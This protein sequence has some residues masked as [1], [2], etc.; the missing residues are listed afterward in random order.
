ML[1]ADLLWQLLDYLYILNILFAIGIIFY[2]RRNPTVTLT[3]LL[4]LFLMPVLGL[5]LYL[6]LGQDLRKK[7]MFYLKK[8]EEESFLPKLEQQDQYLHNNQ[9]LFLNPRSSEYRDIIHLHLNS[10]QSLFS[11]NNKVDIFND[12][13]ELFQAMAASIQRAEKYIHLEYYII[14]NDA[15]GRS[16]RDILSRKAAEGVEVRLLYDGMGCIHLP[17]RF[18]Q[19]LLQAG[20]EVA[21]FLPPF[22][23]FVNLRMNYRNHRKICI[24]DGEEGYIGGFN[25]GDE[26]LGLSKKYGYWR[27]THLRIRGTALDGLHL[28]FLLDWRYA[29]DHDFQLREDFFPQRAPQG[30]TGVQIVSSGPDAKWSSIKDGFLKMIGSARQNIYIQTPYF[31]PDESILAA[32]KIA[33]LSGLDVRLMI[34]GKADHLIVHWANLSYVGEMLEAGVR[35]YAYSE[36]RFLHSKVMMVDGFVSTVGSANMDIRS[37]HLNFE[38]NA[39]IYDESVCR[40]LQAAFFRDIKNSQEITM[41]IYRARPVYARMK[42][43]VSRLLSP[44]L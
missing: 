15:T 11:Q 21:S 18:F 3:W 26:Y 16:L 20:G 40:N 9:M 29:C 35:C 33:A 39:F 28:R 44:L 32:L 42:E 30:N 37:F 2:E 14:Q 1:N 4:V 13:Q 17:R 36:Q 23:P 38:V 31:I 12:G 22:F 25:I 34:P 19:P 27:D 10:S 8:E 5:I 24:I 7:K 41:E 43:A 6:F